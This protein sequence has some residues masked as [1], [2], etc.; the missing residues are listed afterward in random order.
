M[1]CGVRG[2]LPALVTSFDEEGRIDPDR[3]GGHVE[4]LIER[5]IAGLF[6]A[7][8]TGEGLSLPVEERE[9]LLDFLAGRF[10]SRLALIAHVAHPVVEEARRLARH[11]AGAGARAVAAV[12]PIYYRATIEGLRRYYEAIASAADIPFLGYYLPDYT[13]LEM[14]AEEVERELLPIPRFAGMKFTSP[15]HFLLRAIAERAGGRLTLY[16]GYDEMALSGL[17]CGCGGLIGSHYN[18]FPEVW[19]HLCEAYER[20]DLEEANRWMGRGVRIVEALRPFPTIPAVKAAMR[21]RGV[22]AGDTRPPLE[23]VDGALLDAVGRALE[24]IPFEA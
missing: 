13:G 19:V 20:G 12:G 23:P 11:A 3:I 17:L 9:R 8:T 5:G 10:G 22:D 24:G 4:W 1:E 15:D 18:A 2:V 6:V 21:L 7:G 16:S 14:T